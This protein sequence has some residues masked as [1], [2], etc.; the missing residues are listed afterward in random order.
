V[1]V[2]SAGFAPLSGYWK[3]SVPEDESPPE[4]ITSDEDKAL[5]TL[6][7]VDRVR[8]AFEVFPLDERERLALSALLEAPGSTAQAL[9]ETC[10]WMPSGW[11]TQ[12]LLLCQRRR[13][14][15]WPGGMA[16][17]ITNGLIITALTVYDSETLGFRPRPE[18]TAALWTALRAS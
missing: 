14:F 3:R 13:R 1:S 18:L 12:M 8:M 17:D 10:G 5:L 16:Q 15:L 9:S 2:F 4:D 11:R 6:P 7:R